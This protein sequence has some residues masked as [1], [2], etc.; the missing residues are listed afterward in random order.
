VV[1]KEKHVSIKLPY[2]IKQQWHSEQTKLLTIPVPG[3]GMTSMT[4]QKEYEISKRE[5]RHY[6]Q[7][8]NSSSAGNLKNRL[9][10]SLVIQ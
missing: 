1:H 4:L 8:P 2:D 3:S 10:T 9:E 5:I 7:N 6:Q